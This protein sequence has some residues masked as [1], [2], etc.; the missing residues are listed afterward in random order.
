MKALPRQNCAFELAK[1]RGCVRQL[2]AARRLSATRGLPAARCL[3]IIGAVC[4][5]ALS[6][7]QPKRPAS[8]TAAVA[9][10]FFLGAFQL[11]MAWLYLQVT[12][13][14]G[15]PL[16]LVQMFFSAIFGVVMFSGGY[17]ALRGRTR[18]TLIVTGVTMIIVNVATE[19]YGISAGAPVV[20][21][22]VALLG[23]L[24]PALIVGLLMQP[25][26]KNFFLAFD[27]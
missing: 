5:S 8:V 21:T 3:P 23:V 12:A 24:V 16:G 17:A 9:I 20:V 15:N 19:I 7:G 13:R 2:S 14:S 22:I 18:M 25:S 27:D 4:G 6:A 11:V 1:A 26:S 10:A